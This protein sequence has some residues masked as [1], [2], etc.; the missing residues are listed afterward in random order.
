MGR[1][2][3]LNEQTNLCAGRCGGVETVE[4]VLEL[5]TLGCNRAQGF[6]FSRAVDLLAA[7]HLIASQPFREEAATAR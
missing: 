4:Q 2:D 1:S 7:D 3:T 6:Y 5:Q